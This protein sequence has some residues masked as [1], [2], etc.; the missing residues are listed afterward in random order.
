LDKAELDYTFFKKHQPQNT[1]KLRN[2]GKL[3]L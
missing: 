3:R 2:I 1:E